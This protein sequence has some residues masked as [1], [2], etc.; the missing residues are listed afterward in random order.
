MLN[1]QQK[2]RAI[3]FLSTGY[4]K[5]FVAGVYTLIVFGLGYVFSG[6]IIGLLMLL[7]L[8]AF[9]LFITKYSSKEYLF[10]SDDESYSAYMHRNLTSGII[11]TWLVVYWFDGHPTIISGFFGLFLLA[12]V[13]S[14]LNKYVEHNTAE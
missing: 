8:L 1:E 4:N 5:L 11:T 10:A 14:I 12:I 2:Q 9:I 13:F 6:F 7:S 3:D